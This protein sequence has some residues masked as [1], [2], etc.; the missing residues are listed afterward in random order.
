MHLTNFADIHSRTAR[1][2]QSSRHVTAQVLVSDQSAFFITSIHL[3]RT[4]ALFYIHTYS[5]GL[6]LLRAA[7]FRSQTGAFSTGRGA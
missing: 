1:S 7:K 2:F 6:L 3:G 5:I 4:V